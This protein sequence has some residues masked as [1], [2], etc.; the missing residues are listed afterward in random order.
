[1]IDLP[2]QDLD[3]FSKGYAIRKGLLEGV[4]D[5]TGMHPRSG[6]DVNFTRENAR[7]NLAGILGVSPDVL[8]A[9][10]AEE[11]APKPWPQLPPASAPEPGPDD[12][13]PSWTVYLASATEAEAVAAL[14]GLTVRVDAQAALAAEAVGQARQ[15]VMAA[16][17]SAPAWTA[18][19][20]ESAVDA[21]PEPDDPVA[22]ESESS[23][24]WT[25]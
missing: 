7:D 3:R 11:T 8:A 17:L 22:E 24:E 9:M 5:R 20:I 18:S 10:E 1:M 23:E 13:A 4:F 25:L 14:A 12:P 15:P 6:M 21:E 16:C 19:P 2:I